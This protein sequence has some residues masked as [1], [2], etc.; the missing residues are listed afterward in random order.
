M[1]IELDPIAS[2]LNTTAINNNFQKIEDQLNTKVLNRQGLGAG[3]ANQMLVALDM[4]SRDVLNVNNLNAQE[5]IV[6]GKSVDA[7]ATTA[8]NA[9]TSAS[10]SAVAA[11]LSEDSAEADAIRAEAAANTSDALVLRTELENGTTF[12]VDATV[13]GRGVVA[14][15]SIASLLSQ[16]QRSDITYQV[17]SYHTGLTLGGGEFEWFASGDKATHDGGLFIDPS[18][19]FPA[20]WDDDTQ[21]N[22]WFTAS[23][24]TGVFRRAGRDEAINACSYG[25]KADYNRTTG[26]GTDD[27]IAI[28]KALSKNSVVVLP[29]RGIR[30]TKSINLTLKYGGALL[31]GTGGSFIGGAFVG[32][33]I[34]GDTGIYPVIDRG[35]SQNVKISDVVIIP[36]LTTPAS[37]GILDQRVTISQY[38]QFNVLERC[39]I[40]MKTNP[41]ANGGTGTIGVCN[42]AAEIG[43][44]RDCY[45]K[46]DTG[47][48]FGT[49]LSP[50]NVASLYATQGGPTSCSTLVFEGATVVH[51]YDIVGAPLVLKGAAF[52]QGDIYVAGAGG[53]GSH[54]FRFIGLQRAHNLRLFVEFQEKCGLIDGLYGCFIESLGSFSP[55]RNVKTRG[56][57]QGFTDSTL[58]FTPTISDAYTSPDYWLEGT[59]ADI[60]RNC[61]IIAS[62]PP[63]V[64]FVVPTNETFNLFNNTFSGSNTSQVTKQAFKT[65]TSDFG[66]RPLRLGAQDFWVDN[67]SMLRQ[68][69]GAGTSH[70]DGV[71]LGKKVLTPATATSTGAPGQWAATATFYYA[72]VGD[73]TTHSWVRVALAA[74]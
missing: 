67:F 31:V 22:T 50:Y 30:V 9:A 71:P 73:G 53:V 46:G 40:D 51:S 56:D 34:A 41:A 42:V 43:A 6:K 1:T 66:D 19:V 16:P 8:S 57:F 54:G 3:Q 25:V 36:G 24:G 47:Y 58:K 15:D 11:G 64:R 70:N 20:N 37:V 45:I 39:F 74:W 60:V 44:V 2:V 12:L 28:N 69:T 27:I 33:V 29:P 7:L 62:A 32:T 49:T 23:T 65:R 68:K 4:N 21:K 18:R 72:Y 55:V 63:A 48:Y 14:V 26:A 52:V 17:K 10:A 59:A 61:E 38:A 5:V 35:G 13:V